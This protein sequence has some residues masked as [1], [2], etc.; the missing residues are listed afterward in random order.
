M[1]KM[2]CIYIKE[3]IRLAFKHHTLLGITQNQRN[4]VHVLRPNHG[5]TDHLTPSEP[6]TAL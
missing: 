1:S 3:T 2:E 5:K 4:G 6:L